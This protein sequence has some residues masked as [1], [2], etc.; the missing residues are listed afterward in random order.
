MQYFYK[1]KEQTQLYLQELPSLY[2]NFTTNNKGILNMYRL[3]ISLEK[4]C[5]S[6]TRYNN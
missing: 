5:R 1:R 4:Y 6:V 3:I 2:E